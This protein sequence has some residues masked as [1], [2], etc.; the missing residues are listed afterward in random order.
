MGSHNQASA[1]DD[2]AHD[3]DE[4]HFSVKEYAIGFIL[5]VILTVIPFWLVMDGVLS[6][7]AATAIAIM[8]LGAIQIVVHMIYFLHM[9][10]KS[11][12][13]WTAMALIFTVI[14][15]FITLVGSLW[16]MHHLNTKMMPTMEHVRQAP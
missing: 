10:T 2:H 5:S 9:N 8:V 1:H 3:E 14:I 16:V 11:E 7:P 12:G 4:M 13:G 6:T 15:V